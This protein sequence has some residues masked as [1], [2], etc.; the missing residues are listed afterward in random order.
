MDEQI[1][2]GEKPISVETSS[3]NV[4]NLINVKVENNKKK[5]NFK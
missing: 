2:T 4:A 5:N 1:K 3:E